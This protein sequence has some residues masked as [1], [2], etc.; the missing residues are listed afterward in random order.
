MVVVAVNVRPCKGRLELEL[1]Q[2]QF[3]A[4]DL[5]RRDPVVRP[6][7][8]ALARPEE[9]GSRCRQ[10]TSRLGVEAVEATRFAAI[11]RPQVLRE[12]AVRCVEVEE[13]GGREAPESVHHAGWRRD[14]CTRSE[15]VL[16]V[17]HEKGQLALE[18][19]ERI[20]VLAVNVRRRAGLCVR[21]ATSP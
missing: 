9:G 17:V 4:T 2:R 21:D 16:L 6:Q 15:R 14:E 18:H 7:R 1:D 8:L 12:A 19:V 5:D 10:A 20:S 13:P 3:L 11:E